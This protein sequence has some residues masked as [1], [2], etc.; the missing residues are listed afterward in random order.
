[1]V[2]VPLLMMWAAVRG[3]AEPAGASGA[4]AA[5]ALQKT[6]EWVRPH[7][8]SSFGAAVASSP[9]VVAVGAP[10][11]GKA[12]I[13]E[14]KYA[15]EYHPKINPNIK[16]AI[17]EDLWHGAGVQLRGGEGFG[18]AVACTDLLVVVGDPALSRVL[19]FAKRLDPESG[20]GGWPR[21]AVIKPPDAAAGFGEALELAT[22]RLVVGA[23][24]AR[25][26]FYFHRTPLTGEKLLQELRGEDIISPM[27]RWKWKFIEALDG[28]RWAGFGASVDTEAEGVII[29]APGAGRALIYGW[30]KQNERRGLYAP[31]LLES[32]TLVPEPHVLE[33]PYSNEPG[34]GRTVGLIKSTAVVGWDNPEPVAVFKHSPEENETEGW[35]DSVNATRSLAKFGEDDVGS[36]AWAERLPGGG[37]AGG[38]R[39]PKKSSLLSPSL[40]TMARAAARGVAV[41]AQYADGESEGQ[42]MEHEVGLEVWHGSVRTL[43]LQPEQ[44]G[45]PRLQ[46][47]AADA[48]APLW[49][50][51]VSLPDEGMVLIYEWIHQS[52]FDGHEPDPDAG[53]ADA[54]AFLLVMVFLSLMYLWNRQ[55]FTRI[56]R[57]KITKQSR[58]V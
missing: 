27:V 55:A 19:V 51:A 20:T 56:Y 38:L 23:P 9:H 53:A 17:H 52:W 1:M 41:L 54:F 14:R 5:W 35:F 40:E 4:E 34:F 47:A 12:F 37:G 48:G 11:E 43:P 46:I 22:F 8:A 31:S 6:A 36:P 21:E 29:G 13:Y 39:G 2:H 24:E 25:K 26:A 30:K 50:V 28:H 18:R 44:S 16:L 32:D 3:A 33:R 7:N 58:A 57:K 15:G 10:I 45:S 42:F 49:H